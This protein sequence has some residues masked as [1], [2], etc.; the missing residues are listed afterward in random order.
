MIVEAVL[1]T[2]YLG[3]VAMRA[4]L[5]VRVAHAQAP[6][7]PH[8]GAGVDVAQAILS[9][10]PRLADVLA[11]TVRALPDARFLWLVDEGDAAAQATCAAL[12]TA[13]PAAEIDVIVTP[14]APDR[15][16]PKLWKLEAARRVS[17][18]PVLLVLDDDTRMSAP[19]LGA[20]MRALET[21]DL[22]TSLPVYRPGSDWPS[23][24]LAQFVANNAAVTYLSLQPWI[25]PVTINGMA[26]AIRRATLD[27]MGGFA[28]LFAHLTDD[29][30]VAT[31]VRAGG[32]A[33]A[34]VAATH[35]VETTVRDLGHYRQL[36]HRWTL[37]AL[38]LLRT[39]PIRVQA[40]VTLVLG[41]P[42]VLLMLQV[43]RAWLVPSPVAWVVL[44]V[45]LTIRSIVIVSL[46]RAVGTPGLH[47]AGASIASEL[48][49]PL[50]LVHALVSPV[51]VWRTRRYRVRANDDFEAA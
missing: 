21:H 30:A 37:F 1:G 34:Q 50:H 23:Q 45:V 38:L 51:I 49:Q 2:A 46:H 48:W 6:A 11:D 20:L 27:A 42:P 33:L 28:P 17:S 18:A 41:V 13:H 10:D 12:K 8:R 9:G 35:E 43:L 47:R 44:G 3:I 4:A 22:A 24:L 5:A 19:T 40:L 31:R 7:P 26:Y 15:T 14:P 36:M 16:N 39:Q 25:A 29:L 32:G